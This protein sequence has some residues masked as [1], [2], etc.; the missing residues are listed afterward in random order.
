MTDNTNAIHNPTYNN[1]CNCRLSGDVQ[2]LNHGLERTYESITSFS[3]DTNR[4]VWEQ[5][6]LDSEGEPKYYNLNRGESTAAV[7][8]V[9]VEELNQGSPE[10]EIN[11]HGRLDMEKSSSQSLEERHLYHVLEG[12]T[13]RLNEGVGESREE[14]KELINH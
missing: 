5:G 10:I 9:S 2:A 12:P 8:Q 7:C 11:N 13:T 1:G 3:A 6:T 14:R 4:I